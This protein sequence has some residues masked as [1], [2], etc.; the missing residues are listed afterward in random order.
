MSTTMIMNCLS[1]CT[2]PEMSGLLM[3]GMKTTRLAEEMME[4]SIATQARGQK[5]VGLVHEIQGAFSGLNRKL[6]AAS[7]QAVMNTLNGDKMKD[8]IATA[9]EMDDLAL[10]CLNKS[11]Q[12]KE[13]MVQGTRSLQGTAK[14]DGSECD[15]DSDTSEHEL[16]DLEADIVEIEQCNKDIHTMTVFS[17]AKKGTRAFQVLGDKAGVIQKTFERIQELCA[18]IT[19]ASQT[20]VSENCCSQL[21]AGINTVKSMLNSAKLTNL[22]VRLTEAAKRLIHAMKSLVLVA[23]EKFQD[24]AEQFQAGRKIKNWVHG[25]KEQGAKLLD[26]VQPDRNGQNLRG[27]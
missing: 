14:G 15:T 7:F 23:F 8:A 13:T 4:L 21:K 20:V 9:R 12:M 16:S 19:M 22:V 27:E 25:F 24:F 5:V 2:D 6:N 18:S 10:N 3:A 17:A 11:S 1:P 26:G